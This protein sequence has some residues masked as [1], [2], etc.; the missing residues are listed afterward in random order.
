[1]KK[2]MFTLALALPMAAVMI[3]GCQSKET[4]VEQALDN[5]QDAKEEV[6]EA[7]QELN[8]LLNDSI[9]LFI[10]ESGEI[11]IGYEASMTEIK[12]RLANN[13]EENQI[14]LENNLAMLEQKSGE[15]KT[16]LEEY[17]EDGRENWISFKDE[18]N[19]DMEELGNALKDLKEDNV[20]PSM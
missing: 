18:F 15:M 6:V 8:Q 13:K 3:T 16:K 5:L 9:Q 10:K 11:I 4:K 14:T 1:M 20:K 12:T 2:T 17:K 19:Y 7:D